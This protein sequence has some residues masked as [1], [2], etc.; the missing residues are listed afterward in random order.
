M[1]P[2][3]GKVKLDLGRWY[4]RYAPIPLGKSAVVDRYLNAGLRSCSRRRSVRT[5]F[6]ATFA[7]DTQDVIQRYLYMFG[8]WEPH[9]TRWLRGR[10]QTGDVFVDVGA[11]IGYYSVLAS[12]CVGA[13]GGVVAIEASPAMHE[14]L[15][16]NVK[17]NRCANLRTV[18]AAVSDRDE[19]LTFNLASSHNLGA[20][21]MV[22]YD[23]PAESVF[24]VEAHSLP[25]VLTEE[26]LTR[27][28]VIKIDVEGAEGAVIRGLAPVL[29]RLRPDA[30][31]TVEVA[32]D[33]M[34]IVGDSVSELLEAL[35]GHGFHTYRL[36]NDYSAVGYP[37]AVHGAR[38]VP[39]RWREPV[40]E[41]SDLVFS[42]IDAESL[43]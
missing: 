21:S 36:V 43:P 11:N 28:R 30:E 5:R 9:L 24:E 40:V 6:G 8:M 20:T 26:E 1:I 42:R 10:L 14:T 31:V 22:P 33:R 19:L 32:P 12:R 35:T 18:N 29:G 3:L 2:A 17:A 15:L 4:V 16:G 25:Q 37:D 13:T 27:A 38:C 41:Q 39:V 34:A 7:I 23:G